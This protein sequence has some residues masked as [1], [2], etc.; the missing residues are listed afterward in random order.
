MKN[1]IRQSKLE[2][3][4]QTKIETFLASM[5]TG[6]LGLSDEGSP[7]VIPLNFVYY[8]GDIFIHG[9]SE[10]RKVD[11]IRDNPSACF[12][13]S[14]DMGTMTNPVPAKT[15]TAYMSVMLFGEI[16]YISDL[17][18]ATVIMQK[19]LDKY[20]PGYYNQPLASSHVDKYRSSLGSKTAVFRLKTLHVSAK[21]NPVQMGAKFYN[22]KKVHHD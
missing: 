20:V 8:M 19:M 15:D 7:Y 2:V 11:I 16:E 18:T 21:E 22:G 9:A 5:K 10:G 13:V 12:T 4:D 1:Q 3:N 6:Y 17:V 14:E